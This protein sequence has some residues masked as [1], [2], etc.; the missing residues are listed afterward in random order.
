MLFFKRIILQLGMGEHIFNSS[1]QAAEVDKF[2]CIWGQLYIVNFRSTRESYV[3][4]PCLKQQL[5]MRFAL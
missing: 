5:H 2:M 4:K 1:I 3:V